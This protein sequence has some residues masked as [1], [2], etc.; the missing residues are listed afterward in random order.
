MVACFGVPKKVMI[1]LIVLFLGVCRLSNT[2]DS[3][4]KEC[5]K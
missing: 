2:N 1:D 3:L 5:D 4:P